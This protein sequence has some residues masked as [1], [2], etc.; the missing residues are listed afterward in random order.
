MKRVKIFLI[1][2]TLLLFSTQVF[3]QQDAQ[4]SQ[5]MFNG[6]YLNPG[7][8]GIEGVTRGTLI[9][10]VQWLGYES[11]SYPDQDPTA[12]GSPKS[13][14]LS[15]TTKLPKNYGGAGIYVLNDRL[16]PI[17]NLDVQLSYA[18]HFKVKT[19]TMGVGVR[20]GFFSQ[21]VR[22]NFYH[23]VDETDPIYLYFKNNGNVSQL[24]GDLTAGVWYNTK[25]YYGGVSFTHIPKAQFS[26][27]YDSITSRLINHM[28]LT[29]GY[30]FLLG[31]NIVITPSALIQTDLNELTYLFGGLATYNN[32]IW[33]GINFRQSLAQR[34]VSKKGKTLS[35]DDIILYVGI[36]VLKNKQGNDA[37]R[38]GY[39]FDFV[40]SG[41][42]AKKRTS[43]EVLLSY[44]A[45]PPWG[46]PKPK[47]RTP[48]YRHEEN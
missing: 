30:N 16:G 5:Y 8:A 33:A 48:R 11:T 12:F 47:V 27:G 7:Y 39:A 25:K 18:Y 38:I 29:G 41:V 36:N 46:L 45:P 28:Y 37:L 17:R 35:N 32:K 10:R 24:K 14:I 3:A 31:T 15:G 43:H 9:N 44:M 13:F 40:T 26:L 42:N 34:E 23:V 1:Y 19:G 21:K 4:F 2:F 20:G 22:G 6:L